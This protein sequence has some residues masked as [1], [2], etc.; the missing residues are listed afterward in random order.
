MAEK[1]IEQSA[2]ARAFRTEQ[3][4]GRVQNNQSVRPVC[5]SIFQM[6]AD[7]KRQVEFEAFGKLINGRLHIDP[8]YNE[9][10]LIIAEIYAMNPAALIKVNGAETEV[11]FLA[12]TRTL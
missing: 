2:F 8:L 11:F 1:N 10:C 3:F 7:V 6:L 9:L 12:N 5:Q 4:P